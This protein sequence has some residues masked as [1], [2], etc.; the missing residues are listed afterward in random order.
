MKRKRRA[1]GASPVVRHPSLPFEKMD[2]PGSW[3]GESVG[4]GY[5]LG[6]TYLYEELERVAPRSALAERVVRLGS[7]GR[8]VRENYLEKGLEVPEDKAEKIATVS[9]LLGSLGQSLWKVRAFRSPG[10]DFELRALSQAD[11]L[12]AGEGA[13]LIRSHGFTFFSAAFFADQGFSIEFIKAG[14]EA[15]PDY[16]VFCNSDRFACEATTK[17]PAATIP[18]GLDIPG[19]WAHVHDCVLKKKGKFRDPAYRDGVLLIDTSTI[20]H[21]IQNAPLQTADLHSLEDYDE[22]VRAKESH[23]GYPP[24]RSDRLIKYDDSPFSQGVQELQRLLAGTSVR[25]VMV[26]RRLVEK[27]GE[28]F[29]RREGNM[30]LGSIKGRRFWRYFKSVLIFPGD[31][32]RITGLDLPDRP[33]RSDSSPEE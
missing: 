11:E 16:F 25:N 7:A 21:L 5:E 23:L 28:A 10:Y 6:A 32:I 1:T 29:F 31:G 33:G 27:R 22:A 12:F 2:D 30:I 8:Y 20:S 14:Q 24:G 15:S 4:L 13:R 19:Y 3:T 18:E 9:I 26:W 17:E